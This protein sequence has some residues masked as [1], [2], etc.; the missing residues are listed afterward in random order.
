[1]IIVIAR[2]LFC[3]LNQKV[4]Q[5][6]NQKKSTKKNKTPGP[7]ATAAAAA[8]KVK[9][10]AEADVEAEEKGRLTAAQGVVTC[11]DLNQLGALMEEASAS[12]TVGQDLSLEIARA[13]WNYDTADFIY[14]KKSKSKVKLQGAGGGPHSHLDE[15]IRQQIQEKA[16]NATILAAHSYSTVEKVILLKQCKIFAT[17]P[18]HALRDVA[19][20]VKRAKRVSWA[21]T[22]S[23]SAP[24]RSSSRRTGASLACVRRGQS[25]ARRA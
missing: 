16:F 12:G 22:R 23:L 17:A 25:T 2:D 3:F 13:G 7:E 9:E 24:D 19:A 10:D 21:S 11:E 20:R 4:V 8:A 15:R 18:D 5:K 14:A 1:M 6:K